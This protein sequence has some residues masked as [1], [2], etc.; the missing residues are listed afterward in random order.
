MRPRAFEKDLTH[1][2]EEFGVLAP[3]PVR[4]AMCE[5]EPRSD[6]GREAHRHLLVP[7]GACAPDLDRD[8]E[9]PHQ[10]GPLPG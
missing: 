9:H 2:P 3:E 8:V 7:P 1:A 6:R 10:I 4:H 5:S